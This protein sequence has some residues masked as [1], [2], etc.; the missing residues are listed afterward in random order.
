MTLFMFKMNE[1]ESPPRRI[2]LTTQPQNLKC[3]KIPK[4]NKKKTIK[5]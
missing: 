5:Q 2:N 3:N 1:M 4:N